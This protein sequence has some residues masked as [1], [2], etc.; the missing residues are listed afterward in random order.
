MHQLDASP[1][2]HPANAI[3]PIVV[4][5]V[6]RHAFRRAVL[7][8]GKHRRP[9]IATTALAYLDALLSRARIATAE[10]VRLR[11]QTAE[12]ARAFSSTKL[13]RRLFALAPEQVHAAADDVL[14]LLVTDRNA[15][16]HGIRFALATKPSAIVELASRA[17][18]AEPGLTSL[19]VY[20]LQTHAA[21]RIDLEPA[22]P[23]PV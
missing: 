22:R 13:A 7:M 11:T 23:H 21:R 20:D 3:D 12:A 17:M 6:L 16:C 14:D 8:R 19:L 18:L 2:H 10:R 15:R 5:N 1:P 4:E 9:D